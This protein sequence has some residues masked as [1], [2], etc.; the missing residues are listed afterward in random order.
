MSTDYQLLLTAL[1]RI[2]NA[3]QNLYLLARLSRAAEGL[4]PDG[5]YIQKERDIAEKI[6]QSNRNSNEEEG[7]ML[8]EEYKQALVEFLTNKKNNG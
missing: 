3:E 1:I 6:F 2:V 8:W 5:D 7:K 4:F